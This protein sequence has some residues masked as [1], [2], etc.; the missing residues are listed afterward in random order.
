VWSI[1][2]PIFL[3]RQ[4]W[5][6]ARDRRFLTD[7]T[8]VLL[9]PVPVVVAAV[10]SFYLQTYH[11]VVLDWVGMFAAVFALVGI[12]WRWGP[13]L[14]RW[15]PTR[16]WIPCPTFAAAVGAGFFV[17]GQIGTRATS[18][19]GPYP[20]V[21]FT[22]LGL[23]WLAIGLMAMTLDET[24]S[25]E[26]ARF[27]FVLGVIGF[28]TALSP[29]TEFALG[30]VGLIPIDVVALILLIRL[31]Y[32]RTGSPRAAEVPPGARGALARAPG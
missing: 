10:G 1:S 6:N 25:G 24:A 19:L 7:R 11:I 8:L 15:R 23:A 14:S 13:R 21:G 17:I 12:A 22:L 4:F 9:A 28:Y 29:L 3:A 18:A 16:P 26:R 27:A 5:P 2:F 30:R 31:Y 32:R 20:V